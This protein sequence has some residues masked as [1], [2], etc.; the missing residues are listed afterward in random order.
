MDETPTEHT[1]RS[2]FRAAVPRFVCAV[3]LLALAGGLMLVFSQS[4]GAFFPGYRQF[5][6]GIIGVLATVSSIAPCSLWDLLLIPIAIAAVATFA[7]CIVRK[8]SL[9]KWV[10]TVCVIVAALLLF[11]V[12][13]WGLNHYAPPLAND[14]GIAVE[15]YSADEL[16]DAT[17]Y[18]LEHAA[19]LALTMP[20]DQE[21][22]LERQDFSELAGIAGASYKDLAGEYPVFEGCTTPVKELLLMGEPL[23]YSGHTG[24]YWPFTGE[25]NVPANTAV[26]E[27]PFIQCHEAA[28]RLGIASEQEANFAAFLACTEGDAARDARFAYSG[29]F[30]AFCYC[31]NALYANYPQ[32][33]DTFVEKVIGPEVDPTNAKTYGARLVLFDRYRATEHYQVYEGPAKEVGTTMND[34]Y[35]KAFDEESGIKSYGEVVDYLIAWHLKTSR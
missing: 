23:L 27:M 35:L 11:L 15:E 33:T 13:S 5:S 31:L 1:H 28:H 18:Y 32:R 9:W 24:I 30:E 19:A 10:S 20:R 14:L 22:D 6:K 8:R 25:A 21:M 26:A 3:A 29:Y 17:A 12:G 16:E 7:W 2:R 34:T 4:D